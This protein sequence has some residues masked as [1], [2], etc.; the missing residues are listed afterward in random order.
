MRAG[1]RA[2]VRRHLTEVIRRFPRDGLADAAL[3]ELARREQAD[4]QPAQARRYLEQL[5]GHDGEP[6]L[7]E[8]ARYLRC[9]LELEVHHDA[10]ALT[11]LGAFRRDFPSSPHDAEVLA[12]LIGLYQVRD[13][14]RRAL[15]LLDEYTRR[16]PSGPLDARARRT[17]CE[18]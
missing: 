18:H 4:G 7:R 5:L 14:C 9:R 11:C 15:P 16:Y 17:R 8:P 3:Y 12:L 2:A 1:D 10:E 13:D 6:E